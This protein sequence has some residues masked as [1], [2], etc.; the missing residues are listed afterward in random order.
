MT[1]LGLPA[2]IEFSADSFF[3]KILKLIKIN[4]NSYTRFQNYRYTA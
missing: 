3:N 2:I 1:Y 4:K